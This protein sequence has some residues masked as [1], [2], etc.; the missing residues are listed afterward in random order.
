MIL[1]E[2]LKLSCEVACVLRGGEFIN[3]SNVSADPIVLLW[4]LV[5]M[6][7]ELVRT[8]HAQLDILS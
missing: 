1:A 7:T 6:Q 8:R 2:P 3:E 5:I 4:I